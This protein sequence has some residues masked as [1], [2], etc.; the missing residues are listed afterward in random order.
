MNVFGADPS[1]GGT[2]KH[3]ERLGRLGSEFGC[4]AWYLTGVAPSLHAPGPE[5]ALSGPRGG[6][7]QKARRILRDAT[8]LNTG[9]LRTVLAAARPD[10]VHTHNLAGI[11]T[12]IWAAAHGLGIPVLHT[13]HDYYMTCPRSTLLDRDGEPCKRGRHPHCIVRAMLIRRWEPCVSGFSANTRFLLDAHRGRFPAAR[14]FLVGNPM[15]VDASLEAIPSPVGLATVGYL[16]SLETNKGVHLLI[17]ALPAI[18]TLG[19]RLAIAG[20]GRLA[21]RVRATADA[22][23]HVLS[24]WGTVSGRT[25]REFISS[26]DMGILPSIWLEPGGP[27]NALIEWI[28]AGRPVLASARGGLSEALAIPGVG[29]VEPST[30]G[31]ASALADCVAEKRWSSWLSEI[32]RGPSRLTEANWMERYVSIYGELVAG[33][34]C[35]QGVP[36]A[37]P[38]AER[39]CASD[40]F[41]SVNL[42]K[43]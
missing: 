18:A 23:P 3:L 17:D 8:A 4:E 5:L 20:T 32:K 40:R 21:E 1:V 38:T 11:S 22:H 12:A 37:L 33:A 28:R 41:G 19:L 36:R 2:E 39:S 26:C 9:R 10:V 42:K 14:R 30:R 27:P 6:P 15:E 7:V 34:N 29:E 16:G 13:A 31:I 24:Y 25:K 43:K 35:Q